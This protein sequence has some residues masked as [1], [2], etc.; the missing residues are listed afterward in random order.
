MLPRTQVIPPTWESHHQPASESAMTA[1][2][3]VTT[4]P[5][6]KPTFD[7]QTGRSIYPTAAPSYIGPCRVQNTA[8]IAG[9]PQIGQK[10]QPTSS[11]LL[12]IPLS[13][14]ELP[15]GA[16]AE[17]TSARDPKFVG[18]K[19]VVTGTHGGSIV[20]QRTYLCDEWTPTVR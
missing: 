3:R 10:D 17:V 9:A 8:R 4:Q 6:G 15:V 18:T 7:A 19:L 2:C 11:Y 5:A 13:G 12:A 20:W 14:P 1:T 16:V